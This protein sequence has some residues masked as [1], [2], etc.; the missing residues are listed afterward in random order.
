MGEACDLNK[1]SYIQHLE[2]TLKPW[3]N[4]NKPLQKT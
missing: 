4:E 2:L 1:G 3:D